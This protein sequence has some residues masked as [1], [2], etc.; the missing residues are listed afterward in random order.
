[1]SAIAGIVCLNRHVS[2]DSVETLTSMLEAMKPTVQCSIET[3]SMLNSKAVIGKVAYGLDRSSSRKQKDKE[4]PVQVYYAG[5]IY[6]EQAFEGCLEDFVLE[7]YH[8]LGWEN[9]AKGLNGCFVLVIVDSRDDSVTLVTDHTSSYPIFVMMHDDKFYFAS[10]VKALTVVKELP[11]EPDI[12][13]VLSLAVSESYSLRRTIVRN[14]NQMDYATVCRIKEG[15]VRYCSYWRFTVEP[16]RDRGAEFYLDSFQNLL[17]QAVKR[18]TKTGLGA[19]LLSGG[20]DS[21]GIISCMD[22]PRMVKAVSYTEREKSARH[23]KGDFTVAEKVTRHLGME[24]L[25]FCVDPCDFLNALRESVYVTEGASGFVFENIW[26]DIQQ[27]TGVDYLLAGDQVLGF[28]HG[29]TL[30]S[31]LLPSL[32]VFSLKGRNQLQALLRKDRLRPFIQQSEADFN[33]IMA[34]CSTRNPNDAIDELY[35]SQRLIHFVNPK[36]R[37]IS[38][39]GM[40]IRNPWLDLDVMNFVSRL[41]ARY[42]IGK[43]LFKKAIEQINPDLYQIPMA[44]EGETIDFRFYLDKAEQE[45]KEVSKIIFSDNP[46]LEEFFEVSN[47]RRLVDEVCTGRV[48]RESVVKFDPKTLLPSPIR[49]KV[50]TLYYLAKPRPRF[51]G[52]SLLLR[53][54]TVAVALRY[55]ANRF[56]A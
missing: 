39:Y 25:T 56:R 4:K 21:R 26:G 20:I 17:R 29:W 35:M 28:G 3:Y 33:D 24:F 27:R 46:L 16:E 42:R 22:D 40:Q 53:I 19:I 31:R 12:S 54:I 1:M 11:C 55:L 50:R 23:K 6:N 41:P 37:V 15:Q 45:Q 8:R 5:E 7:R 48:N 30:N 9:F 32:A 47:I 36:R 14:V 52:S 2:V 51:S 38:R 43:S 10:E 44:K 13:S 34:S 18:R 49:G